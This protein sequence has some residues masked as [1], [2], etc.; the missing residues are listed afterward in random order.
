M[1]FVGLDVGL[2]NLCGKT[3]NDNVKERRETIADLSVQYF[4]E[5]SVVSMNKSFGSFFCQLSLSLTTPCMCFPSH[6]LLYG[7]NLS[8]IAFRQK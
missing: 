6:Y 4:L 3:S 7:L 5:T 8:F 1:C 2:E